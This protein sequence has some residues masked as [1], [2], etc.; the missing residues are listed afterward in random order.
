M[1]GFFHLWWGD[2]ASFL[3][4]GRYSAYVWSSVAVV[5]IALAGE[6][7]ALRRRARSLAQRELP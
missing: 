6:H 7:W 4:M 2:W 3:R 1:S 5:V